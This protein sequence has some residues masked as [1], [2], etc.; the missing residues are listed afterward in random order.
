MKTVANPRRRFLFQLALLLLTASAVASVAVAQPGSAVPLRYGC[1]QGQTFAYRVNIKADRDDHED[2]FTGIISYDVKSASADQINVVYHGGLSRNKKNKPSANRNSGRPFGGPFGPGFNIPRPPSPFDRPTM[3]GTTQTTNDITLT[4][5][6]E[7]QSLEGTSQLPYLL[8]NLSLMVFEPLPEQPQNQWTVDAGLTITNKQERSGPPFF[9]PRGFPGSPFDREDPERRTAASDKT[10]F[11]IQQADGDRVVIQKTYRLSSP[12]ADGR[13]F[14]ING[15]GTWTFNREL[16]IPDALQFQQTLTI[17]DGQTTTAIPM[18][19]TY[20]RMSSEEL[21]QHQ[22]EQKARQEEAKKKLEQMQKDRAAKPLSAADKKKFLED[23]KSTNTSRKISALQRLKGK[24]TTT[25]DAE[26]ARAIAPLRNDGNRML[27]D[28]AKKAYEVWS[29]GN[30][31][32]FGEEMSASAAEKSQQD[33]AKSNPF[34]VT[35][36]RGMRTWSDD[37]GQFSVEAEFVEVKGDNV[38]LKRKDGEQMSVPLSRLSAKDQTVVKQ[39][40]K[41]K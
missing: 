11:A 28:M 34:Q 35:S 9:G 14:D 7:V 30:E 22:E 31:D 23:L 21:K 33:T 38:I 2:L 17:R 27:S 6:G 1:K 3:T 10:S 25:G 20:N 13:G 26:L 5:T 18:T 19:V 29:G 37:S 16:G 39:L 32:G 36:D 41:D 12:V 24:K 15:N 4:T 8:G 40:R